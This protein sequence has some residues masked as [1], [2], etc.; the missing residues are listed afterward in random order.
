MAK[1]YYNRRNTTETKKQIIT[2]YPEYIVCYP[3][4]NI[5][6]SH[7]VSTLHAADSII[8]LDEGKIIQRGTHEELVREEGLYQE[9]N[10]LQK[11]EHHGERGQK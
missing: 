8:V 1:L 11:L 4:T 3:K 10:N 7:R 5:I 6:I 9:I 2:R